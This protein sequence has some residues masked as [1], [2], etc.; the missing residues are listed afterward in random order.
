LA[1]F[2]EL[3]ERAMF[4][5]G[6]RFNEGKVRFWLALHF[7]PN[8]CC[9]CFLFPDRFLGQLSEFEELFERAAKRVSGEEGKVRFWLALY[10]S[11]HSSPSFSVIGRPK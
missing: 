11:P 10:F 2:Y 3:L 9:I 6:K 1:G 8:S 7:S 5:E 4:P